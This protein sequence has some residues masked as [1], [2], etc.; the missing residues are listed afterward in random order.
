[1]KNSREEWPPI[2]VGEGHENED[3]K[4]G[5]LFISFFGRSRWLSA[6]STPEIFNQ[7]NV[8]SCIVYFWT[9]EISYL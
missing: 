2:D 8:I 5:V 4:G 7:G 3:L 9:R 6:I 1:M